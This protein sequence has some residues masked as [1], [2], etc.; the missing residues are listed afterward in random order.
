MDGNSTVSLSGEKPRAS[1]NPVILKRLNTASSKLVSVLIYGKRES[2]SCRV[3][4][5]I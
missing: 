4:S 2:E 3:V 5:V 1:Y